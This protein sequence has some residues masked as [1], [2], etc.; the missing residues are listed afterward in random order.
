MKYFERIAQRKKQ[1]AAPLRQPLNAQTQPSEPSQHNSLFGI[2]HADNKGKPLCNQSGDY[3][4]LCSREDFDNSTPDT[5]CGRCMRMLGI[6]DDWHKTVYLSQRQEELLIAIYLKTDNAA[7]GCWC[8]ATDLIIDKS[9]GK[10]TSFHRSLRRL[11]RRGLIEKKANKHNKVSVRLTRDCLQSEDLKD[12]FRGG[13]F[14]NKCLFGNRIISEPS[15]ERTLLSQSWM[16]CHLVPCD[17]CSHSSCV[18]Q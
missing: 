11:E 3:L 1:T 2:I 5:K 10:W 4:Q 14:G 13:H 12:L 6:P 18:S 8:F 9:G 7:W 17:A 15:E 16:F